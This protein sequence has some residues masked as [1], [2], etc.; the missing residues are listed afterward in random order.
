MSHKKHWHGVRQRLNI[1]AMITSL[2]MPDAPARPATVRDRS[3][4]AIS[5]T[6]E[7]FYIAGTILEI[8][9]DTSLIRGRVQHCRELGPD[10][11]AI[12]IE[13]LEDIDVGNTPFNTGQT[14]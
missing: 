8:E 12:G 10:E 5:L 11:Y 2:D 1:P 14:H 9:L 13:I 7:E 6:G 3:H 4:S